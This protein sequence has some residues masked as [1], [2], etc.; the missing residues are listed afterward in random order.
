ME[1]DIILALDLGRYNSVACWYDPRTRVAE[2][3][4][5]QTTP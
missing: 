2:F 4:S 1:T 3:R 5:I